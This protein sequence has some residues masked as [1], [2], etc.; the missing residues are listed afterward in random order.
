MDTYQGTGLTLVDIQDEVC[1]RCFKNTSTF[2]SLIT[3]WVNEV[4]QKISILANGRWW[5]LEKTADLSIAG[6]DNSVELPVDFFEL[7]DSASVK[8]MTSNAFLKGLDHKEFEETVSGGSVEGQPVKYTIFSQ[9]ESSARIMKFY[10]ASEGQRTIRIDYYKVLPDLTA[11]DDV[12]LI[13]YWY[14]HLLVD[15]AVM[16]GQEH[17]QQAQLAELARSSWI[18]GISQL[19]IEADHRPDLVRVMRRKWGW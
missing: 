16:R 13:P 7:V 15:F 3:N 11:E 10:P 5:W 6:S 9:T 18:D 2:R 14:H 12:S 17:R 19:V 1:R 8:D 4:Q